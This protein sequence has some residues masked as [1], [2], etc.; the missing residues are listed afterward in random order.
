MNN[1]Q[2][3]EKFKF[4]FQILNILNSFTKLNRFNN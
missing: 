4:K 3:N 2:N 1:K